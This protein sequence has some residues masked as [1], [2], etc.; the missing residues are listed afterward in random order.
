MNRM[1]W[2]VVLALGAVVAW[3][4]IFRQPQTVVV[5]STGD[6]SN[7]SGSDWAN[8]LKGIG[9]AA[10]GVGDLIG[11]F[12]SFFGSDDGGSDGDGDFSTPEPM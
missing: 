3:L 8:I 7:P 10:K 11:S 4:A 1:M 5:P 9:D 6:G 12:G 2:L